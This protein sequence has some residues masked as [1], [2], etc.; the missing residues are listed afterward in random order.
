LNTRPKYVASTTLTDPQWANTTV[1]SGDLA[2]AIGELRAEPGGELQVWGSSNDTVSLPPATP[3]PAQG[4]T[5]VISGSRT[6]VWSSRSSN[7]EQVTSVAV[8]QRTC[9][10]RLCSRRQQINGSHLT[11]MS[12]GPLPL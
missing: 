2:A 12:G 8:Q 3:L 5:S 7:L 4:V 10:L 1:L 9:T 11:T 6:M